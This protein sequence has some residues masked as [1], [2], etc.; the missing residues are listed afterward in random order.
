[1]TLCIQKL[2]LRLFRFRQGLLRAD[3]ENSVTFYSLESVPDI[4]KMFDRKVEQHV[5]DALSREISGQ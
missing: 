2:P 4:L 5:L 3:A 1:M